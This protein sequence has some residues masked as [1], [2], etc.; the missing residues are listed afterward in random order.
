MITTLY[1]I[2]HAESVYRHGEER[3]RGLSEKGHLA[4]SHVA[5]MLSKEDIRLIV[6]SPYERAIQTVK[7]LA[8]LSG[9][10]IQT[11]EELRERSIVGVDLE[12]PWEQC[13]KAIR[14]SFTDK[15][16]ALSGGETT[17]EA[18]Q[19]V[20]PVI[21]RL[22]REYEGQGIA[23]GTHGNIMTILLNYFDPSY[24]FEFW[25]TAS[26]PDVYKLSFSEGRL[27]E[28]QRLWIG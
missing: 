6:S 28:V 7:P 21:E 16:Y 22:L 4:A 3:N 19:R 9:L 23:V 5:T 2:R 1:L 10:I 11:Y 24:G 20:I 15:D 18:Q 8:E 25:Q 13:V 14:L 26:M 12:V 17:N 27:I